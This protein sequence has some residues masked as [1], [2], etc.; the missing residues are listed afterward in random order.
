[1]AGT[2]PTCAAPRAQPD[3]PFACSACWSRKIMQG[4]K[5]G[6]PVAQEGAEAAEADEAPTP[7]V[8]AVE[9][10]R[11]DRPCGRDPERVLTA[12]SNGID[13]SSLVSLAGRR[14]SR[15]RRRRPS[16][17][18]GLPAAASAGYERQW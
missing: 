9:G 13:T 6:A 2:C 17:P 18:T 15:F 14:G 8:T 1:M 7:D 16:P 10:V 11:S 12:S 3:G 4:R 5:G